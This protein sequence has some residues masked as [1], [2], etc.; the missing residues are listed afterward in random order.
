MTVV[1]LAVACGGPVGKRVWGALSV[2]HVKFCNSPVFNIIAPP[3]VVPG[4][5]VPD[6]L[7]DSRRNFPSYSRAWEGSC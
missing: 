4:S 6:I 7:C 5:S 2:Q 3:S 1:V